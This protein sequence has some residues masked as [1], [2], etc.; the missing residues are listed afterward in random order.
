MVAVVVVVVIVI[1]VVDFGFEFW[2]CL[3]ALR[4]AIV[5]STLFHRG[6]FF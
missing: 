2:S 4:S 3:F 6:F 5:H 1:V